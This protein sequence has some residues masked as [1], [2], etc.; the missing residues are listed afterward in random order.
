MQWNNH[1]R[2]RMLLRLLGLTLTAGFLV[3]CQPEAKETAE[4]APR[5]VWAEPVRVSGGVESFKL[6]GTIEP[7]SDARIAFRV[8]GKIVARRVDVGDV[9]KKGDVLAVLED[10]DY[11][12]ALRANEA[13]EHAARVQADNANAE[14]K[15]VTQLRKK[16]HTSESALDAATTAAEASRQNL[17]AAVQRRSLSENE[18]NYT[19]LRAE[20]PGVVTSVFA[21]AGQVVSAGAPVVSIARADAPEAQVSIPEAMISVIE[22]VSA[23]VELWSAPGKALKARLREVA[24]EADDAARMFQARFAIDDPE[25]IARLGMSATVTL[26]YPARQ[27]A[28]V[29]PLSALWY[30]GDEAFVWTGVEGGDRVE[31]APVQVLELG[32]DQALVA[33]ALAP[34]DLVI[35]MGAHRIDDKL[36]VLVRRR[37]AEKPLRVGGLK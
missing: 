1:K 5:I 31:A 27:D 24:P 16:G 19:I 6:T 3:G 33:S 11:R 18:L 9:V 23:T 20:A 37:E 8:G 30:D 22:E 26:S 21:E 10:A 14:L 2:G 36:P 15:R 35:S 4:T 7:K 34:G 17:E 25:H 29:V 32:E 28:L 13:L 12:Y